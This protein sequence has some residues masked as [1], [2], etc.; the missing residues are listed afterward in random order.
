M[1]LLHHVRVRERGGP[2]GSRTR[3]ARETTGHPEPLNDRT[4]E[5]KSRCGRRDLHPGLRDGTAR[6]CYYTTPAREMTL[7]GLEP[8]LAD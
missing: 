7:T 4:M 6:C 2:D 3:I 1:L 5:A 8:V